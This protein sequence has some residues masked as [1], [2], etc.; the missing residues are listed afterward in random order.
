MERLENW[1]HQL[2]LSI[3]HAHTLLL[4][5]FMWWIST[6]IF[7]IPLYL[8]ILFL[9]FKVLTKKSLVLFL[10]FVLLSVALSDLASVHLFKNVF[11]R[12]RPSHHLILS[13]H[14]HFYTLPDGTLYRGGAY[15]FI[16]S[17]AANFMA[18]SAAS[19][20]VLRK[21]Y[22]WLIWLLMVCLFL[23]CISRVYLGVH[24][25]SDVFAG[26]LVGASITTLLYKS[27]FNK[28]FRQ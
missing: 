1:D 16:S 12:Y 22:R 27:Y 5:E 2:L 6:K 11:L 3:N 23:V 13:N 21:H 10:V 15:G 7:W 24:Y 17:H 18:I 8:F 19:W 9:A 20:W 28:G 14:L 25:P 26:A 4:D